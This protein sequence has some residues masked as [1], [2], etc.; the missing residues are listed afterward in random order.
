MVTSSAQCSKWR[1]HTNT[2]LFGSLFWSTHFFFIPRKC[3]W[4]WTLQSAGNILS[5]GSANERWCYIVMSCIIGWVH[6]QNDP[7]KWCPLLFWL[8]SVL[9]PV[10]TDLS[11]KQWWFSSLMPRYW[12]MHVVYIVLT[13]CLVCSFPQHRWGGSHCC[14]IMN[15]IAW[16]NVLVTKS[17][18]IGL[19]LTLV[20]LHIQ[21]RIFSVFI[22][23]TY[24]RVVL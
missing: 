12:E 3:T 6:T 11:L 13:L 20:N 4:I 24:S 23:T 15:K 9:I 8:L 5:M 21:L 18:C 14:L 16:V 1:Y 22:I 7:W 19:M 17:S 10:Q 2:F